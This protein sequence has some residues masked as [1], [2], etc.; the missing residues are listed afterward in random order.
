MI[1]RGG[2]QIFLLLYF[3][4]YICFYAYAWDPHAIGIHIV[5]TY[6][7]LSLHPPAP[8]FPTHK[9][10]IIALEDNKKWMEERAPEWRLAG[11][12]GPTT[13]PAD[14]PP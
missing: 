4:C 2:I 6:L 10:L 9:A 5:F 8:S 1:F 11:P 3:C 12:T 7:I 14:H 13:R